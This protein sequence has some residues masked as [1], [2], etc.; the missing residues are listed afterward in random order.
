MAMVLAGR[1]LVVARQGRLLASCGLARADCVVASDGRRLLGS[2]RAQETNARM[3]RQQIYPSV[4]HRTYMV[5]GTRCFNDGFGSR[6]RGH[7]RASR[8]HDA[9]HHQ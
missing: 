1:W 7:R 9:C 5:L 4:D 2:R 3:R 6:D 8:G